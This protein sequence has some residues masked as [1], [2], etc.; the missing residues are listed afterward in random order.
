MSES[1]EQNLEAFCTACK[2]DLSK[3]DHAEDCTIL[4]K[5]KADQAA[6][7]AE[8][9]K[10]DADDA[11]RIAAEKARLELEE[12]NKNKIAQMTEEL[13][14]AKTKS[15]Q[16]RLKN[17]ILDRITKLVP[18]EK[19][20]R[21]D[22]LAKYSLNDLAKIYKD[23]LAL[24]KEDKNRKYKVSCPICADVL[25]KADTLEQAREIQKEHKKKKHPTNYGN[26]LILSILLSI[27]AAGAYGV[28]KLYQKKKK[29][30]CSDCGDKKQ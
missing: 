8:K 9:A 23:L 7:E 15:E 20:D 24:V 16:D 18:E 28:Y 13:K 6:R 4:A 30:G 17:T 2:V 11:S 10:Q 12:I 27:T 3:N 5:Q 19:F 29:K 21:A 14:N 1:T 26:I 22:F 25:G